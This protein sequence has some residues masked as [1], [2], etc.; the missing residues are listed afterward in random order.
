MH[1]KGENKQITN[2]DIPRRAWNYELRI[3]TRNCIRRFT[4]LN[5]VLTLATLSVA[6]LLSQFYFPS[7]L[8]SYG[9]LP[10]VLRKSPAIRIKVKQF[11]SYM[12]Y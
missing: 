11:L 6:L 3:E 4:S 8:R 7:S 1:T 9:M 10:F 5:N 2:A 12:F